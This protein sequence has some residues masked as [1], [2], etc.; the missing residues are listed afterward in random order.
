MDDKPKQ[1]TIESEDPV[2]PEPALDQQPEQP[3]T[4]NGPEF[5]AYSKNTMWYFALAGV[6]LVICA[7]L[8]FLIKD[9]ITIVVIIVAFFSVG[10]YAGR[11]PKDISY[12]VDNTG[13]QIA[14]KKYFFES[15]RNFNVTSENGY[16]TA[17]LFPLK[18]FAFTVSLSFTKENEQIV[19]NLLTQHLPF[20]KH[21]PDIID[22]LMTSIRF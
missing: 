6:C 19:L 10:V 9:I 15:F 13:A 12:S 1:E 18:R 17:T 7:I 4:W 22:R 2:L 11:K 14:G 5:V 20:E 21:K 16:T 3:I 8:Y